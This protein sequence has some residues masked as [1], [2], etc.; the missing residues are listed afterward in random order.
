ME[1]PRGVGDLACGGLVKSLFDEK[2]DGRINNLTPSSF[3]EIGI[4]YLCG[5]I[6]Y[7]GRLL[8]HKFKVP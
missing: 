1:K 7:F 8:L 5:Y 3:N 4:F 2:L 6:F